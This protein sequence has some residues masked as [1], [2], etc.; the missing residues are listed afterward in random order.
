MNKRNNT[1]YNKREISAFCMQI[2]LLLTSGIS[3]AEGI[4]ILS[5]DADD[6]DKKKIL[7][8]IKEEVDS[9]I[10]F[11][12][13]L[14]NSKAFPEYMTQM[15]DIA[16]TTGNLDTVMK[17]MADYYER[18]ADLTDNI[19]KAV[20]YPIMLIVM[21]VTVLFVLFYKVMPIFEDVYSQLGASLSDVTKTAMKFGRYA[22]LVVLI[23][24]VILAIIC[25][26]MMYGA[27]KGSSLGLS[28]KIRD[29][30]DKRSKISRYRSLSRMM[31]VM[32]MSVEVG[33]STEEGFEMASKITDNKTVKDALDR[34]IEEAKTS[35]DEDPYNIWICS[36][37]FDSMKIQMIK[38]GQK[39]GNL[40][41]V[42]T[43]MAVE[44]ADAADRSLENT[45]NRFEPT[46]VAI[47]A[48]CVGIVLL[49]VMLPLAGLLSSIG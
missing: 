27:S 14:K 23:L 39:T 7:A 25:I 42:M 30:F 37:I 19:R 18:D 22:S 20:T 45:M 11:A 49:S 40:D 46:I 35:T 24:S 21:L 47:L 38:V 16:E 34:C 10:R 41:E 31:S 43:R 33:L 8:D 44:Y 6:K 1:I 5:D 36:G 15:A 32:A 2:S 26:I 29:I 48:I 13:A 3:I 9:G 28:N 12:D 4:G 17:S